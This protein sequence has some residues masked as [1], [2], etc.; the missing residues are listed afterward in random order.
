MESEYWFVLKQS[1]FVWEKGSD[2]YFYDSASFIGQRFVLEDSET[3]RFV[4]AIADIDNLYSLLLKQEELKTTGIQYIVEKLVDLGLAELINKRKISEKPIQLPPILNLKSNVHRL[5]DGTQTDMAVGENVLKNLLVL[6]IKLDSNATPLFINKLVRM[7][8]CLSHASLLELA[9]H[10]YSLSLSIPD[11][12][13]KQLE[14]LP[15]LKRFVLS[16]D[17]GSC[18]L[19]EQL[20]ERFSSRIIFDFDVTPAPDS[21]AIVEK[22]DKMEVDLNYNFRIFSEEDFSWTSKLIDV[23]QIKKYQIIPRN[24]GR[25]LD[26]FKSCVYVDEQD[27]LDSRQ[28]KQNIFAHQALNT[29]DFGKLT[30]TTDGKVYANLHHRTIGSID[31]DLRML[32]YK[33]MSKGSSW[34]RVRDMSPCSKCIYQWLCPSPSDYELEI[35]KPN[36]CHVVGNE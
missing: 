1:V 16:L 36:L 8:D 6:N 9:V 13:W 11:T 27:I 29:N 25:N 22:L 21:Q 20:K 12:F 30:I 19:V 18:Y 7:L 14:I 2:C 26:F 35:G 32:V 15:C 28:T 5:I 33:E 3:I 34:L 17:E 4:K 31:E 10:G 23:Y 24:N